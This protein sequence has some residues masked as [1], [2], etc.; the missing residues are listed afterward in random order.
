MVWSETHM[1]LVKMKNKQPGKFE[2]S[3]YTLPGK[4]ALDFYKGEVYPRYPKSFPL[5]GIKAQAFGTPPSEAGHKLYALVSY[6]NN[7][8]PSAVVLKCMSSHEFTDDVRGR[9]RDNNLC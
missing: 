8:E 4:E 2:L 3:I 9:S 5:F 7:H 6:S 1:R